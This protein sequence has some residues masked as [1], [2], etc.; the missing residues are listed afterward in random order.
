MSVYPQYSNMFI[1]IKKYVYYK[2]ITSGLQGHLYV[3]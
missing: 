3:V 2:N 1:K